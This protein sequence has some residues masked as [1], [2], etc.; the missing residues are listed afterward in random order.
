MDTKSMKI[1]LNTKFGKVQ[2]IEYQENKV[3]V[4]SE[5]QYKKL[6]NS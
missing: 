2:A 1:D 6:Q 5:E 4:I 3:F